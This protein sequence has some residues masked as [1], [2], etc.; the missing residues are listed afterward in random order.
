MLQ[1]DHASH[2]DGGITQRYPTG[3][4]FVG[5]CA[6]ID[7]VVV[8]ACA[9]V[10]VR[11]GEANDLSRMQVGLSLQ[12]LLIEVPETGH[13]AEVLVL[14]RTDDLKERFCSRKDGLKESTMEVQND[15]SIKEPLQPEV[16]ILSILFPQ[17]LNREARIGRLKPSH[18]LRYHFQC[19]AIAD[20][21]LDERSHAIVFLSTWPGAT[22]ETNR[23]V[24]QNIPIARASDRRW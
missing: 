11:L 18:S 10:L 6:Q 7:Q 17:L 5:P 24:G 20:Q 21:W 9:V 16:A 23:G 12:K 14:L 1:V 15:V 8:S 22:P 3:T 19:R 4:E 13:G 2:F